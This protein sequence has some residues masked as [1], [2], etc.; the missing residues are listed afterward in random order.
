MGGC[1]KTIADDLHTNLA[2]YMRLNPCF[3]LTSFAAGAI[4]FKASK[5]PGY[6]A[7]RAKQVA[8][9]FV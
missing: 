9:V 5:R 7:R 4:T 2:I 3:L 8:T 6:E 1:E